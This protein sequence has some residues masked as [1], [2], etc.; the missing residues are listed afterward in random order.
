[1]GSSLSAASLKEA[2]MSVSDLWPGN[3][4]HL[5]QGLLGIVSVFKTLAVCR[6]V[7]VRA[8]IHVCE[9]V[10]MHAHIFVNVH[11]CVC[12]SVCVWFF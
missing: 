3:H 12:V 6:C 7:H 11:V 10:S 5:Q 4:V 8:Y 2:L 9:C 1:M